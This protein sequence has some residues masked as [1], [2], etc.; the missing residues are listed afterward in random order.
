MCHHIT[1]SCYFSSFN[2]VSRPRSNWRK[3]RGRERVCVKCLKNIKIP[4]YQVKCC[5]NDMYWRV[6]IWL[7]VSN[8]VLPKSKNYIASI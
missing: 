4:W 1:F 7:L 3:T 8:I 6:S 2:L 5:N